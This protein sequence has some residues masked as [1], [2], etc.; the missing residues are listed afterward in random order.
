MPDLD[1]RLN[2]YRPDLAAESLEGRV[3]AARFTAGHPAQVA[4]GVADLRRRPGAGEPL[5][6]Q[7]LSGEV[8]TVYDEA[9]GWAWVQ[10]ETDG[11]VGYVES[12]ALGREAAETTHA[13]TVLRTFLF[14]VPDLKAPPLDALSM[15]GSV[16]V[17]GTDGAYSQVRFGG[18]QGWL[19]SRHLAPL[20]DSAPDY[21]E[22]ALQFL[23]VPYLWGGKGS[24]GMD[25]SGH[26]QVVLARAGIPCP[27]DSDTQA[28]SLGQ[29]VDWQPGRTRLQRGD[30]IYFPGHVAIALDETQ[31]VSANAHAMMVSIEPL[32]EL[33]ERVKAESGGTGITAVRR[34]ARPAV[35]A[36]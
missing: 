28:E 5:D 31:V 3:E 8:V 17:G 24:L 14:P 7:L 32:S 15:T 34:L 2:A 4:R 23:G 12:A 30:L 10:N 11:Y 21:V 22:T 19:Y 27:R 26:I 9:G 13:V 20:G 25:C 1:P 18:Q 16:A 6:S 36:V 35:A 33:E 29:A